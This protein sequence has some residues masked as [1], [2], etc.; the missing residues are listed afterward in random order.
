MSFINIKRRSSLVVFFART[1]LLFIV[2]SLFSSAF[3]YK[4]GA[5]SAAL[6][7][8]QSIFGFYTVFGSDRIG[9]PFRQATSP[10]R[11]LLAATGCEQISSSI[12][13]GIINSGRH[14]FLGQRHLVEQGSS[15]IIWA[16]NFVG[17]QEKF[18]PL[19]GGANRLAA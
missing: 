19:T 18:Q 5:P 16:G 10:N 2:A 6:L 11:S 17:T 9:I 4:V 12:D 8:L 1:C 15:V 13:L 14:P 3:F 7:P